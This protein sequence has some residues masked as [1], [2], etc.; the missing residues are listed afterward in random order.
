MQ[1]V[2]LLHTLVYNMY[3]IL[4]IFCYIV[5]CYNFHVIDE[6]NSEKS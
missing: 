2:F 1:G 5:G 6:K 3:V 4:D